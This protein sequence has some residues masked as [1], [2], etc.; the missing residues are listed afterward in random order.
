MPISNVLD[1][2]TDPLAADEP[3]TNLVSATLVEHLGTA[4]LAVSGQQVPMPGLLQLRPFLR[5]YLGRPV[6]VGVRPEHLQDA[7]VGRP[8]AAGPA[9]VVLHGVVRRIQPVGPEQ[10][11]HLELAD[12]DGDRS[13]APTLVALVSGRSRAGVDEP[14]MLAFDI[15]H[16]MVFDVDSGRVLP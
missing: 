5:R 10:F 9:V 3:P 13:P 4:V 1:R 7:M 12:T 11:I 6:V 16:L 8:A 2:N 15:Q 14:I